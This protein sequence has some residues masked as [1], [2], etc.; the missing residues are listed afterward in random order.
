MYGFDRSESMS[1][2]GGADTIYG[3]AHS[4]GVYGDNGSDKLYGNTANDYVVGG[5]GSDKLYGGENADSIWVAKGKPGPDFSDDYVH[6]GSGK[7]QIRSASDGPSTDYTHRGVDRIYGDSGDDYISV[8]WND[9]PGD[10]AKDI[11]ACGPGHD[12]V[13]FNEGVDVVDDTCEGKVAY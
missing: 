9:G 12:V 2:K 13:L 8:A 6:G 10:S 3:R 11:V 4:D 5:A 1:G 7:D